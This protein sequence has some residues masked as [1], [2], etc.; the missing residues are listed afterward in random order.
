MCAIHSNANVCVCVCACACVYATTSFSSHRNF[1]MELPNDNGLTKKSF[2]TPAIMSLSAPQ[3][4][5][6][7]PRATR[8]RSE[9]NKDGSCD[10]FNRN[11]LCF[12]F[13]RLSLWGIIKV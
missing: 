7:R 6:T 1:V 8:L 2:R 3:R 4:Q 5:G 9:S 11:S 13:R 10:C 12:G